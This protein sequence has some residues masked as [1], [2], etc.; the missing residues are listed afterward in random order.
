MADN[1]LTREVKS[2]KRGLFVYFGGWRYHPQK[3]TRAVLGQEIRLE[4]PFHCSDA[5]AVV[6]VGGR[7][8]VWRQ[9]GE[10]NNPVPFFKKRIRGTNHCAASWI[11]NDEYVTFVRR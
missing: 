1:L 3:R 11:G 10:P 9:V 4:S 2:S 7:K 5:F 8:E 6:H